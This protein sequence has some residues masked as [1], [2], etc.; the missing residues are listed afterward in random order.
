MKKT[1][2]LLVTLALSC[3]S[4][5]KTVKEATAET[6]SDEASEISFAESITENELKEHLFTYASD[7]YE[8]RET[9]EPGQKMA[10]AYIKAEY[11]KLKI[12]AAKADGDYFQEVP[13]E[14]SKLP[15]GK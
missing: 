8:G 3:N 6:V 1:L 7:E 13:L 9:G 14:I 4:S 12:P 11:E 2:T 5:Q 10:I 15:I